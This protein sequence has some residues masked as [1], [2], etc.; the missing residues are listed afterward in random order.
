MV[1]ELYC[2]ENMCKELQISPRWWLSGLSTSLRTKGLLVRFPVKAHAWV[3]GQVRSPV[4]GATEAT[5]HLKF[6]SLI[7][8]PSV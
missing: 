3:A 6:L 8:F 2:N 7:P 5:T 1:C 4:G